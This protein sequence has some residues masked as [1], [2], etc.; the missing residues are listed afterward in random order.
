MTDLAS[1]GAFF[2]HLANYVSE[3]QASFGTALPL[4]FTKIMI[5]AYDPTDR[6]QDAL[7]TLLRERFGN[8]VLS[9]AFLHSKIMGTAGFGKETLYE[10]EPTTDRTAYN[11]VISSV[12]AINV[13]IE[14]EIVAMWAQGELGV[15]I[16]GAG[17]DEQPHSAGAPT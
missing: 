10:Y 2:S 4:T 15:A 13:A 16:K 5:T 12:N 3:F 6:S 7:A 8:A 9:G 14:R 11:R 1:T 17:L